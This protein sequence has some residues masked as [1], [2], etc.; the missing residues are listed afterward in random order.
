MRKKH[1]N[2]KRQRQLRAQEA[3]Y[4]FSQRQFGL[5]YRKRA[6]RLMKRYGKKEDLAKEETGSVEQAA[7]A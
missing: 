5:S 6:V 4:Q 2:T 7:I 1:N 3:D